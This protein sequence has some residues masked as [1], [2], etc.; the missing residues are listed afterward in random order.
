MGKTKAF[1]SD[2]RSVCEIKKEAD[3]SL[4]KSDFL[5]RILSTANV[6]KF[7]NSVDKFFDFDSQKDIKMKEFGTS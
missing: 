3:M 4:Q 2:A 1:V 6:D 7:F 5:K